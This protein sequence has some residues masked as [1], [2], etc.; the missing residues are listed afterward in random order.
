MTAF[1]LGSGLRL[2]YRAW[3]SE[4][5]AR[6]A[7]PLVLLH[8]I[9]GTADDWD[10]VARGFA[11]ERRVFAIDARGHGSS[12]WSPTAEYSTDAHF[13]DLA[14]ALDAL[15][16]ERCVLAGY[17]M[18]GGVAIL[19]AHAL[20]ERVERLVVVDTY[21]GPEMTEGSRRIAGFI[22]R[23]PQL[24]DGRP[25]F[26]PAIAEAFRRDLQAGE[27]RRMDLWPH[28]DALDCPTLLVRAGASNVLP[29]PVAFE[30]QSRLAH[31]RVVTLEGAT[32]GVLR[33]YA[34]PLIEAMRGFF[35]G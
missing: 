1:V 18:G 20:A 25:R 26:D 4:A 11:G 21:P 32:H 14:C 33:Y 24:A 27:P 30:M 34:P 2:R 19:A 29:E 22:A 5:K 13:A 17:S 15:G 9:G 16:I 7:L 3:L 12:E 6:T 31:A 28:W 23:G 35:E 10:A 8:G